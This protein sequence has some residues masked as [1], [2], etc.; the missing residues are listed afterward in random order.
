MYIRQFW[1]RTDPPPLDDHKAT[2][3]KKGFRTREAWVSSRERSGPKRDDM[4]VKWVRWGDGWCGRVGRGG[5]R[6][7]GREGGREGCNARGVKMSVWKERKDWDM[8]R[9]R[10]M[11]LKWKAVFLK[12]W[13]RVLLRKWKRVF[14]WKCK[15]CFWWRK[16]KVLFLMEKVKWG[17][18]K[19]M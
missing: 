4:R 16:W 14:L 17:V 1:A 5:E 13:K 18:S 9:K 3:L 15:G 8:W 19:E 11:C 10:G 6:G 7:L 2:D 12:K